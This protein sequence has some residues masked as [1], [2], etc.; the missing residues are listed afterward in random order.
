MTSFNILY[1]L[2]TLPTLKWLI[3]N[4]SITLHYKTCH[5]VIYYYK[6]TLYSL[7]IHRFIIIKSRITYNNNCILIILSM[8]IQWCW[9]QLKYFIICIKRFQV[10]RY[11]FRSLSN[12]NYNYSHIAGVSYEFLSVKLEFSSN[13][14]NECNFKLLYYSII[15][16]YNILNS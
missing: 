7:Y 4:L 8:L 10:L 12:N 3:F 1:F 5:N 15:Y 6:G 2:S 11:A 13:K 14:F 9:K 16:Y